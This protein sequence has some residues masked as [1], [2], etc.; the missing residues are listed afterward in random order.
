MSAG[1]F[2]S[3]MY[4]LFL[5]VKDLYRYPDAVREIEELLKTKPKAAQAAS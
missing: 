5:L 3:K 1:L 4:Q 2:C